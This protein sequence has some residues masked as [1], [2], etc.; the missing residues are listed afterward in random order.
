[1]P[2]YDF[3]CLRCKQI[4][5]ELAP[6]DKTGKYP[7]IKCPECGSLRKKL[8]VTC[9]AFNFTNPIGTDRWNSDS[10]GHDYRFKH[11]QPQ[12]AVERAEAERKSHMGANPYNPID[13]VSSGKHFGE[14][15]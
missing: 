2:N 12:V 3:K 10:T 15:K 6:Y 13:D 14:V 11:K 7:K 8:L 4:Y 9:P 5:E 1:M